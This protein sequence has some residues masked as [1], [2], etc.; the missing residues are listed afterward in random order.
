M[1]IMIIITIIIIT[2]MIF[3]FTWEIPFLS[4]FDQKTPKIVSLYLKFGTNTNSNMQN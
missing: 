3:C 2:I 4:K 1:I